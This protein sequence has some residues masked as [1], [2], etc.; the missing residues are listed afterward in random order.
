MRHS[1]GAIARLRVGLGLTT[2]EVAITLCILGIIAAVALPSMSNYLQR[3]R[4]EA[5][6]SQ[7]GA[8]LQFVRSEALAR[9]EG[10]RMSFGADSTGTC[11]V[12][13]TGAA[14]DCRC[15][16]AYAD[17]DARATLIRSFG[18]RLDAGVQVRANVSSA[19]IDPRQGVVSPTM[20][21]RITSNSGAPTIR[22]ALSLL[23]RIRACVSGGPLG[24]L[25]ACAS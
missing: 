1:R 23:G 13:H 8:D 18:L 15:T 2:I 25:P 5:V 14:S 22:M 6:A 9:G 20:T 19:R 3:R 11:Y 7:V 4:L 12:V 17:C 24:T 16:A 10:V 21:V